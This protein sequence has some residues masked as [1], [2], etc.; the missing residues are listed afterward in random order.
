MFWRKIIKY[1]KS[2]LVVSAIA[3]VSLWREM[4]VSL[5]PPIDSIDKWIHGL[6]YLILTFVLYWDC[7]HS[8]LS[9]G[10][11]LGITIVFPILY[12]GFIEIMQEK[13]YSP[14]TG[15]WADWFA[16]CIGVAIGIGI[17]MIIHRWYAR[18]MAQ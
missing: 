4:N 1:W 8:S 17:C 16:D 12:G 13:Y 10:W 18:R 11:R 3:Y 14:R 15:D 9:H 2:I 6:M 7:Q 5:L